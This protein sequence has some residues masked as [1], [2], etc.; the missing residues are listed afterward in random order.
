MAKI[1]KQ[2]ARKAVT[3]TAKHT[4]H[5]TVSKIKRDPLRTGTLLTVGLVLG[6]FA[7]WMIAR[8]GSGS[9][10]PAAAPAPT[11][12]EPSTATAPAGSATSTS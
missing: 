12:T 2:L 8:I 6:G 4:V 3:T 9:D 7:G 5:G 11:P 1:K 10:A